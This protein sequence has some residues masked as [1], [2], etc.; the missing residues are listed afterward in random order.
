MMFVG[1]YVA[2]RNMRPWPAYL[3]TPPARRPFRM[4]RSCGISKKQRGLR[5]EPVK[6]GF[7]RSNLR[8]VLK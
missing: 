5:G 4:G 7:W 8:E 2:G 6:L 3:P 1:V